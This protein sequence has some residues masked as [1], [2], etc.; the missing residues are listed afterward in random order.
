M[1]ELLIRTLLNLIT[2]P[3][4][5]NNLELKFPDNYHYFDGLPPEDILNRLIGCYQE[6]FSK[7]PW[8]NV[9]YSN[10]LRTLP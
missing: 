7:P 10:V 3:F 6:L 8:I 4:S 1:K 5:I 9:V 2:S